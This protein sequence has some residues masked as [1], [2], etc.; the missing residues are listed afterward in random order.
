V[1][2]APF[3]HRYTGAQVIP[4]APPVHAYGAGPGMCRSCGQPS[5]NCRC[6]CRQCRTE[7]KELL[8]DPSSTAKM[9]SSLGSSLGSALGAMH[10]INAAPGAAADDNTGIDTAF[11]GGGCCVHLSVEYALV[12]PT[13]DGSVLIAVKDSEGTLLAWQKT[14]KAGSS[15]TVKESVIT[16]NPGALVVV[17]VK[18]IIARI[19]WCEV[20]SC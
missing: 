1:N 2:R 18:N 3:A 11:V 17:L 9:G 15:Y 12:T 7:A 19:R 5:A 14:V 4:F 16:T 6:G 8:V 20:F 13:T 10:S